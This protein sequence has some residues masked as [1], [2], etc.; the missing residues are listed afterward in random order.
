MEKFVVVKSLARK[1]G[2]AIKA[3]RTITWAKGPQKTF[4]WYR[5]KSD[6]QQRAA[7]LNQTVA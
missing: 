7:A 2:Y 6:A 5:R 1:Y 4:G 3:P